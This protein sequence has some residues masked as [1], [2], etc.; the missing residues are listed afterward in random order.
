M[1]KAKR[2]GSWQI[3]ARSTGK[4]TVSK[5]RRRRRSAAVKSIYWVSIPLSVRDIAR[6]Q[7]F[8]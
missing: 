3:G 7:C 4:V 2:H 8:N 5:W 6:A 1:D